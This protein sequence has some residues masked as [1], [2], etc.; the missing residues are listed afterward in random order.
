MRT[1]TATL[2]LLGVT[3]TWGWTF[4][5][6]HD[7]VAVYGVMGFL[8]LRFAVAAL[9]TGA[10]WGRHLTRH[11]LAAGFWI[12]A[13]LGLGYLCQT[14]GLRF[15]SATNSGLITGLFV[16]LAPLFDHLLYR[17]RL[18]P[19]AWLAVAMS[20]LGMT[21]LTGRTPT[22]L[23]VGDI[24]TFGCAVAFGVHV[25]VLSRHA[26]RHDPRALGT[27]QLLA[28][29]ALF[30]VLWPLSGPL[31]APPPEVWLAILVTGLIA[32]ALAYVVQTAV[33]RHLSAVRTAVILTTEPLFAA[34]FGFLLA[35][36]RLAPLQ[37]L[38][39]AIILAALLVSEL[40]PIMVR[41]RATDLRG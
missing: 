28:L 31:Q 4:V 19:A 26:P 21:M 36:E 14:W 3:I 12:G 20:L 2:L 27:A 7:A 23:A 11:A 18:H 22:D 32:S 13:I 40:V 9:A 33:Q 30:M 34:V 16:V 37:M 15:T 25:A 38:G 35:G 6:V 24:L 5:V 8:A 17:S 39:A 29:A 41:R 10:I 1:S